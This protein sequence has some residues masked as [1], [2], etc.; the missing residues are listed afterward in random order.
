[1]NDLV[2]QVN[3]WYGDSIEYEREW[4]RQAREDFEFYLGEQWDETSRHKL[5][6]EGRPVLTINKIKPAVKLLCGYERQSRM[7]IKCLPMEGSDTRVADILTALIKF[8]MVNNNGEYEQSFQFQ[9]SLVCGRGF[10][11][12]YMDFGEDF[13]NGEVRVRS[14]RPFNVFVD[15]LSAEYD[16]SD[17]A[18]VMRVLQIR[19]NG[20]KRLY[21]EMADNIDSLAVEEPSDLVNFQGAAGS[22]YDVPDGSENRP[23]SKDVLVLKECWYR[24]HGEQDFIGD[25]ETGEVYPTTMA[26]SSLKKLMEG[27]DRFFMVKRVVPRVKLAVVCGN[28]LLEDKESPFSF[29]GYPIIPFFAEYTPSALNCSLKY[30]G[31]VRALKDP[32]RE[33]NKRRAQLLHIINTAANSGW[34]MEHGALRDK[35]ILERFG[36]KPGVVIEVE[37]GRRLERITPVPTPRGYIDLEAISTENIKEI[38]AI[39]ADLLG[40]Y[41]KT[42]PGIAIQLRQRQGIIAVQEI[43]DN[44]RYTKKLLGKFLIRAIQDYYTPEKILRITGSQMDTWDLFDRQEAMLALQGADLS[45][46]DI[47]VDEALSAP[48][49]R[50]ADYQAM[51]ELVRM[52]FPI[53]PELVI[54]ASDLPNKKEIISRLKEEP[55]PYRWRMGNL[56]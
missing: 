27:S 4:R 15:P 7:D 53:P 40:H 49:H 43:F 52:G 2:T 21:P 6:E 39:N 19:R 17:A 32:Q 1:M 5:R 55:D 31:L 46:Y 13:L 38:S 22:G 10:S 44:F 33:I 41:E 25:R 45:R 37:P 36:N 54:E 12:V 16:L 23:L 24:T 14:L 3:Q 9:D 11:Y 35:R 20:L 48:T 26:D 47:V 42:T 30:Q 51:L 34:I 8:I 18:Y 50:V 29:N 56:T 28:A